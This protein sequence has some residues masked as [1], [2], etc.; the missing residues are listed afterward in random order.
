[1]ANN[2]LQKL[3]TKVK[4]NIFYFKIKSRKNVTLFKISLLKKTGL[5]APVKWLYYKI[6]GIEK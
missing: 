1:M 4:Q 2:K 3:I 6:K 5:Y